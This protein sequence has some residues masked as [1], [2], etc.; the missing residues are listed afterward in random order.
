MQIELSREEY[1]LLVEKAPIM[2]WR[3]NL[4]MECDYFNEVWL[5]FTG[6]RME[7]E[8]GNG[9]TTGVHPID[10][11]ACLGI[12]TENFAKRSSFEMEYRLRRFDGVYRWI[13]DRGVPFSAADGVFL[14]YIGSCI[15][16]TESKEAREAQKRAQQNEIEQLH[17][18]LPICS[19]CKRILDDKNSWSQL[20]L[21]ISRHS[22]FH[23]SHGIC[24]DCVK[25]AEEEFNRGSR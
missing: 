19:Y 3:A 10:F 20:E 15:D 11:D 12:Y 17:K 1:R 21:Y 18:L 13:F 5:N 4:T 16:I 14:G 7:E 25:K 23:F 22:N 24:P 8:I 6:R 9:W 2:I